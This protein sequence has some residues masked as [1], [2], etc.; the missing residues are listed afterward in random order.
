MILT[1]EKT[2]VNLLGFEEGTSFKINSEFL[3]KIF[4]I[5]IVFLIFQ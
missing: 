5:S 4:N 1:T 3:G 2:E